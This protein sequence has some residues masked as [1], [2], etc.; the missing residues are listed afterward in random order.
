ML[1]IIY[2]SHMGCI[3]CIEKYVLPNK[4]SSIEWKAGYKMLFNARLLGTHL[5][6]DIKRKVK[7]DPNCDAE[8]SFRKEYA[9][10]P[11]KKFRTFLR[12]HKATFLRNRLLSCCTILAL[13]HLYN[14][15][16]TSIDP[17]FDLHLDMVDFLPSRQS[18]F[19]R[20]PSVTLRETVIR[21]WITIY[22]VLYCMGLYTSLHDALAFF[23]VGIGLDKPEEWP[24]LFGDLREATS[25]SN[26]WSKTWHKLI[27]RSYTSYGKLIS[28]KILR[29]PRNSMA[30]RVFISLFVFT[31]SGCA[32]ALTAW[33]LGLVCGYFEEIGFYCF[34]F[35]AIII[36]MLVIAAFNK[37]TNGYKLNKTVSSGLGYV[38]VFT[39]FFTILPK[40]QFPKIWCTPG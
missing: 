10:D 23:F 29:L 12:S 27:Y 19:R 26:F 24:P 40:N 21:I 6:V 17:I 31:L 14:Y 13:N 4:S 37:L 18:Y 5:Q 15:S 22:W 36:E 39:V 11:A 32:H 7:S 3:L 25:V 30:G 8:D 33:Q 2:T 34:N 1:V 16:M 35:L 20:L 38:W 9:T 28:R